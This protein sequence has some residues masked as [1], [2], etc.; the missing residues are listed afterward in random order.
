[1]PIKRTA[2][3]SE[4]M[5]TRQ[6]DKR[7]A[8]YSELTGAIPAARSLGGFWADDDIKEG[9]VTPRNYM[10]QA[11]TR[12]QEY[13]QARDTAQADRL[14]ANEQIAIVD[15]YRQRAGLQPEGYYL[16]N[17]G[18]AVP[19]DLF[20]EIRRKRTEDDAWENFKANITQTA[21]QNGN[22]IRSAQAKITDGLGNFPVRRMDGRYH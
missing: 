3:L 11:S 20:A 9:L 16:T 12:I 7:T 5:L 22:A 13:Q 15:A 8:T 10:Q 21:L 19:R 14:T 2:T 1:M 18:T 17:E 4:I 6:P